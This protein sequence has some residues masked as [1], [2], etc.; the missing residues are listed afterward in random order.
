[1]KSM[2]RKR[3]RG[4]TLIELIISVGIVAILGSIALAQLRDYTRRA[5]VSE[6]MMALSRCK[7][8]VTENFLT[9]DTAPPPGRWGCEGGG[10]SYY[11]GAIETSAAGVIRVPIANLDGLMNGQFIYL[12]PAKAD[13][14]TPMST[15]S[16]LGKGI[17]S[18]ICGSDWQPVRN[19]LPVNC[20]ADTTTFASQDFL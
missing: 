4:F 1:M 3:Q 6:V 11:A 9:L 14:A 16:D 7:N 5:K 19:A 2:A 8:T 10:G 20:R 13:G 12:V 18:W 15:A 17:S